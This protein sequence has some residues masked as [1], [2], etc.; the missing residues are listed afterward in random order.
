MR[1]TCHTNISFNSTSKMEL[2]KIWDEDLKNK[3][4]KRNRWEWGLGISAL[5]VVFGETVL[6]K[7]SFI[8]VA[9]FS[10][11]Q[12]LKFFIEEA[13]CNY[14]MHKIDIEELNFKD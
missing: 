9:L 12:L 1:D 4:K 14:L 6:F 5:C 2:Y 7:T 3:I 13:H 8:G 10:A 11:V